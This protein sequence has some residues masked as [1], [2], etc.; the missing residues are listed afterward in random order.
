VLEILAKDVR[1]PVPLVPL[2]GFDERKQVAVRHIEGAVFLQSE[3]RSVSVIADAH[4]LYPPNG[5]EAPGLQ[6][7]RYR[8]ADPLEGVVSVSLFPLGQIFRIP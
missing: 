3:G 8:F 7:G 1:V 2:M 5:I 6:V 4:F